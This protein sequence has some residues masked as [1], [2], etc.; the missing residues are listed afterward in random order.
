M[1][2]L[3]PDSGL[4]LKF[5]GGF[6][7]RLNGL[8]VAGFYYNKMRALL[9]YLAV[10][11]EQ[12]HNREALAEL[13]WGGNDPTAA[14]GNLR[15]TLSNLRRALESPTGAVMFSTSKHTLRFI[16]NAYVDVQDF[17]KQ[18]FTRQAPSPENRGADH[19]DE[20][21]LIALYR[22]EF[23]AGLSLP[24]SPGFE[25][26]LQIRREA[27][28]RRA[29]ALLERSANRHEQMGDYGKALQ[30]ALRYIEL[31]PWCEEAHRRVMRLY[32]LNDQI[33]AA[34]VQYETCR[35]LLKKELGVLPSEET[36]QLAERIRK[37]ELRRGSGEPV[38]VSTGHVSTGSTRTASITAPPPHAE[39]RQVTVLYCELALAG[40]DDPDEAMEQLRAPQARC[41]EIIRQFSG[42]IVQALGGGLL[43]YF[44]YPQAHEDAARHA[45]QAALAVTREAAPG[46]EIRV[47]VHT[48]LILT[49]GDA[50]MPDT[51]GKTSRLAVLLR[52]SV[53]PNE[54]AISQETRRMVGGYFDCLSLGVQPL[55]ETRPLEIFKVLRESGARTRLD[56]AARL[57]PLTGR[58]AEIATLMGL[59]EKAVQGVRPVVLIQGEAGIGKSRLLLAL[60]ERL[61]GQPHAIRELRC[62]PEFSQSPFHPLIAMLEAVFGFA[63]GDAP[64]ARFAKLAS[65]LEAHYI[66]APAAIRDAVPLLAQLLS[67]PLAE[68]Y[69]ASG[70]S[71]QKQKERIGAIL[72]D[73]LQSLAGKQPTLLIVEDLHWVDPSTLELLTRLVEQ[74]G[75][76][77]VLV[78]LTARPEFV[79]PWKDGIKQTLTL[80]PLIGA[81]VAQMLAALSE[82]ISATTLRLIMER[83]DGVPLFIE[84]MAKIATL[85]GPARI[86]TTLLDLLAAR[87]DH[88]GEAKTTA[89]LASTLGREFDLNLLRQVSPHDPAALAQ[90]LD[91]LQDAGL[92]LTMSENTRQFKHALIQEAAY[93]SQ[94]RTAR[95]AAHLRVAQILQSDFPDVVAIR[96]ELIAQHFS[97]CG[98]IR[99]SIAYWIKAGQRAARNSANLA[100]IGHY[101]S[102]L[103]LLMALPESHDRDNT[104]FK[105]L[106][107]LCPILYAAKGYGS[108]DA[109]RAS[110]RIAVLDGLVGDSPELFQAKWALVINSL[111]R[112]GARGVP[113]AAIQMLKMAQDDAPKK[114]AAHSL[115]AT[116]SFWLG[117][118]E[119]ARAHDEQALALYHPDQRQQMQ[120]QFGADLSINCMSYLI[121]ALYFLGFQDQAQR[122]CR[123][124]L[125]Q[126]REMDH[127]HSLAQALFFAAVLQRRLK[128]PEKVLSLSAE[129]ITI[130]R[131]HDLSLWLATGEMAHGWALVMLGRQEEGIAEIKSSIAGMRVALR[132]ISVIFLSSLAEAYVHLER[133]DEALDLLAETLADAEKIGD[134]HFLAELHRLEGCCLLGLS[135]ANAAQAESCFAQALAISR[136]QCAKSLELRAATS[137]ARLWQRQGKQEDARRLLGEVYN[138]FTEGFDTLD[139]REAAELLRALG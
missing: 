30:F 41:V 82:G 133:Y 126:A 8:P 101:N 137:M 121:R 94:S 40:I 31:E 15:R 134:N 18:D 135:P 32:A 86:P 54:V 19:P 13:L 35:R 110:A 47:G 58:Q 44:G 90:D 52:Q 124:M 130:A 1:P 104:E 87:I 79:P 99:Q 120:K 38:P 53:A 66:L 100:A 129:A 57:T 136:K 132:G 23:L 24:D 72:L 29:L 10:E 20:E 5:L 14:R 93:Q 139:L 91:A 6:D 138:W 63:P 80:G 22:G 11:R 83:A 7:A 28:H 114:M 3:S 61:A 64:E 113:E 95:Q 125:E 56:A 108:E 73:R 60:K 36:R 69:P 43:A 112:I 12:D 42:H 27:L 84:E 37:G 55:P 51:V 45:V 119:S 96:P 4:Q 71:P 25:D 34:I 131:Q 116:A 111:T 33:G 117:D 97:S 81:D 123:R 59:W 68:H 49:G 122:E 102:G 76:G 103:K 2:S 127:P 109:A 85:D 98:E 9:A 106:V 128:Q 17:I 67:L 50:S 92:I 46:I 21:R 115:A 77:A 26:W 74:T 105:M 118:F 70:L 39:R 89:Q 48:G 78:A 75:G 88:L 107:S 62:F 16:P 65:Y